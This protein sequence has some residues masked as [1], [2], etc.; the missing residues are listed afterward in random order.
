MSLNMSSV[1]RPSPAAIREVAISTCLI[2]SNLIYQELH[3]SDLKLLSLS[4][5]DKQF[6]V[7]Y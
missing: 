6:C 7:R 3:N 1:L 5:L 2:D 4:N